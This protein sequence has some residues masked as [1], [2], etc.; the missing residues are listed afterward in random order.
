MTLTKMASLRKK[1]SALF[2]RMS[3]SIKPY[4]ARARVN[5]PVKA[6]ARKVFFL[7]LLINYREVFRDRIQS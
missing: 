6:V 3:Q 4:L 7:D 2:Y 1:T 5:L